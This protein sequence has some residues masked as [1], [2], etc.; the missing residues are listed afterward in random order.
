VNAF[1]SDNGTLWFIQYCKQNENYDE[2][3]ALGT[4]GS[5][6]LITGIP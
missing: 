4:T 5:L 2:L 6:Q 1:A 3:V